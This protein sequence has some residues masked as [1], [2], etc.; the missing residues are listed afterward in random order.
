MYSLRARAS[1]CSVTALIKQRGENSVTCSSGQARV[2]GSA[3][4]GGYLVPRLHRSP[5]AL[6][7][8]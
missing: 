5:S 6:A 8:Q 2:W 3:Q 7:S 1:I 4:R